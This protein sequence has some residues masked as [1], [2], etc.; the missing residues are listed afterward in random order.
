MDWKEE[1][2]HLLFSPNTFDYSKALDLKRAHIPNKLYR[3]RSLTDKN[4]ATHRFD[5]IVQGSLFLPHPQELNDPFE[6]SSLLGS[7]DPSKYTRKKEHFTKL[8][9]DIMD[10][11]DFEEVFES[12][13][14]YDR[15]LTYVIK[16]SVTKENAELRKA[17]LIEAIMSELENL[18]LR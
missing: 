17:D 9:R 2:L 12:D 14:W 5:E 6:V 3:Y 15:L 11:N 7:N 10:T 18:I 13:N 16:K 1:F 8:Y 4:I